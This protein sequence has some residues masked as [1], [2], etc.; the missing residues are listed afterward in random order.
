MFIKLIFMM[1]FYRQPRFI[2]VPPKTI[3]P[4]PTNPYYR[5]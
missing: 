3:Q 5:Q 2:H 1:A 4:I